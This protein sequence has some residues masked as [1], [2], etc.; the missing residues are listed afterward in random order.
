M[1]R[2]Y[3][4]LLLGSFSLRRWG[5]VVLLVTFLDLPAHASESARSSY[6]AVSAAD[7]GTAVLP[8]TNGLYIREDL[9]YYDGDF[10]DAV[11]GGVFSADAN[12][13]VLG[14]STRLFWYPG[15][16]FLGARYGTYLS[17]ALADG[18]A[19][20]RITTRL[21]GKPERIVREQGD[22]RGMSDI[23]FTPLSLGWKRGD[24]HIKWTETVNL[25]ASDYDTSEA[26]NFGRNYYALNS[27]LGL[28]YRKGTVGPEF[29]IRSGFIWNAENPDTN[30]RTGNEAYVDGSVN[31]RFTSAITAGLSGY[32]YRQLTEDSGE[33]AIFGDFEG[34][35][36]AIGPVFRYFIGKN[37]NRI[38]V[39][40]KW[41][42]Q[43]ESEHHFEGDLFMISLG[44]RF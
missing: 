5:G 25:P 27:S 14:L 24:W 38:S 4:R 23:L 32:A 39:I 12:I 8:P 29:N 35:S 30:Y 20:S 44:T 42:H 37:S 31:W 34:R 41:L 15:V 2:S 28:A 21:P 22:R 6:G 1:T 11:K 43:F 7:F 13:Q 17:F 40:T 33:G 9:W 10:Q 3:H 36:Y 18:E 26:L 16:Q 19:E